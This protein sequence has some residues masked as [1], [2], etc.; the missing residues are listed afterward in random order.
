MMAATYMSK[1][2]RAESR[3]AEERFACRQYTSQCDEHLIIRDV[4]LPA[5]SDVT[6]STTG[7]E[8][9]IV[10]PVAGALLFT[11]PDEAEW[12]VVPGQLVGSFA[13]EVEFFT[14]H[15][16][17]PEEGANFLHVALRDAAL[18]APPG[19]RS[20]A[21][22][23]LTEKNKLIRGSGF[24]EQL[25]IGVYDSR[26]K[27]HYRVRDGHRVAACVI[28]GSFEVEERLMEYRDALCLWD[29]PYIAYQA[30]TEAAILLLIEYLPAKSS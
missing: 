30:L 24:A 28:N 4:Y 12:P 13:R 10:L 18:M 25:M 15:N 26:V 19:S 22:V 1:F 29:T 23:A 3:P 9:H 6:L 17:A 20:I 11:S 8:Q 2:V 5:E 16:A 21:A 7:Y 27:G 14:A